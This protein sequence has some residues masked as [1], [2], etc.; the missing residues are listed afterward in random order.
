MTPYQIQELFLL[1]K[2]TPVQARLYD[3]GK[4]GFYGKDL[5]EERCT[6][7]F[8]VTFSK[9]TEKS[10]YERSKVT[11]LVART[12]EKWMTEQLDIMNQKVCDTLRR[13][14]GSNKNRADLTKQ[15][16]GC[17]NSLYTFSRVLQLPEIPSSWTAL[18]FA[19]EDVIPDWMHS[20]LL[21]L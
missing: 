15:V 21:L 7:T 6:A 10:L 14:G 1:Q 9:I 11:M 19:Q 17:F 12:H 13:M 2:P 18:G 5:D 16:L 8:M 3:S 20:K 4:L